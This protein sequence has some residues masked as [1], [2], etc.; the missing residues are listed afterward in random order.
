MKKYQV[1]IITVAMVFFLFCTSVLATTLMPFEI[2]FDFPEQG[3]GLKY[4]NNVNILISDAQEWQSGIGEIR[5]TAIKHVSPNSTIDSIL[6]NKTI[7]F[8]SGKEHRKLTIPLTVSKNGE[9]EVEVMIMLHAKEVVLNK[10]RTFSIV[11][12]NGLVWSR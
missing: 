3:K 2:T 9:Y 7:K 1:K 10:S 5:L 8:D 11:A 6:I 12:E 4:V